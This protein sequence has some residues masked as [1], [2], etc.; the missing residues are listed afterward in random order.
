MTNFTI[1]LFILSIAPIFALWLFGYYRWA[2]LIVSFIV[3]CVCSGLFAYALHFLK[4]KKMQAEEIFKNA[5]IQAEQTLK[6]QRAELEEEKKKLEKEKIEFERKVSI[7]KDQINSMKH[8]LELKNI[9]IDKVD[10][11]VNNPKKE[12]KEIVEEIRRRMYKYK[13]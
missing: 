5:Q 8:Q 7:W 10:K 1:I 11:A 6:Q 12:L 3:I 13:K 4:K 2:V 9:L